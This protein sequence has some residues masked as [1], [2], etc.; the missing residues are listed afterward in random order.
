MGL[1]G[2]LL[3]TPV[4]HELSVKLG[5][6]VTLY[7]R[8][9]FTDLLANRNHDCAGSRG[10][11][12]VFQLNPYCT[13]NPI[14]PKTPLQKTMD[15]LFE[16]FIWETGLRKFVDTAFYRKSRQG[17]FNF[18]YMDLYQ[19]SYVQQATKERYL[20]KKPGHI[21][22]I[23]ARSVELENVQHQC[24]MFLS[25]HEY[26]VAE[27]FVQKN[28]LKRF[29]VIEPWTNKDYFGI[30]R[31]YPFDRWHD[32]MCAISRLFPDVKSVQ[33]GVRG[34]PVL[35]GCLDATGQLSFREAAALMTYAELFVG[36][37]GG[38]MHAACA[39]CRTAVIVW[40]GLTLPEFAGYPEKHT[41]VSSKVDCAPCGRLGICKQ[42]YLCTKSIKPT[43][44][45]EA[46]AT[47]LADAHR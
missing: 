1:G 23:L 7:S 20:W 35:T 45:I 46:I 29:F 11:S 12:P 30:I 6:C 22:D 44:I 33:I 34:N 21:I 9:K 3:W 24:E 37:E 17:G 4:L 47:V 27:T 39:M 36:T 2:D 10:T 42:N 5:N 28:G 43:Q 32:V 41:I 38:L 16:S 19:H 13:W 18:I 15:Q 26:E 25:P 14:T 8:P 31:S 40:S